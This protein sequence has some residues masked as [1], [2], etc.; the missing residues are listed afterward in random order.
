M[1]KLKT[2]T[3]IGLIWKLS[4]SL[5]WLPARRDPPF[6]FADSFILHL[7]KFSEMI[8][9]YFFY[10]YIKFLFSER[11]QGHNRLTKAYF[12]IF[13]LV[14]SRVISWPLRFYHEFLLHAMRS[15]LKNTSVISFRMLTHEKRYIVSTS[16]TSCD[17]TKKPG[18]WD[19]FSF[20][21]IYRTLG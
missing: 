5:E 19:I 3:A 8:R 9:D 6:Y 11:S 15:N 1:T 12:V 10:L 4:W 16:K 20:F 17:W 7:L 21:D 2:N 14:F 13:S 18:K